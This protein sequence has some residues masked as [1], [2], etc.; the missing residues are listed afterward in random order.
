[1]RVLLFDVIETLF[2]L[3]P[4][5]DRMAGEGLD[6]TYADLFFAQ[7][8]RDA[9]ALSATGIFQPFPTIAAATLKVTLSS[10]GAPADSDQIQR[11]LSAFTELPA[12]P[13]VATALEQ[14]RAASAKVVLLTN[15]SADNTRQLVSQAGLDAW[16]SD[17]VSID[18]YS[19]WKP[20]PGLYQ[21]VCERMNLAVTDATLIAAHAWD[22][23][24]ALRAGLNAVWVKRQ[25]HTFHEL[26][27]APLGQA[28]TLPEAVALALTQ[29]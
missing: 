18:A 26:M 3:Q 5:R 11:I 29:N 21:A 15:G 25:D 1:M 23:H 10:A 16:V 20:H 27:G 13:D 8:L 9:F 24:G 7:L 28:Q 19:L 22:V 2:S 14:A 12:H 17:V 6:E 4:L